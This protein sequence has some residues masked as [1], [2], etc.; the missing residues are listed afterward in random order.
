MCVALFFLFV[1][2]LVVGKFF[3]FFFKFSSI[4]PSMMRS[5]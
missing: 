4:L 3:F 1:E 5:P 2:V